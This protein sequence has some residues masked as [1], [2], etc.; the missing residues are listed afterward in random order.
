MRLGTTSLGSV[1]I[2]SR[3]SAR[4]DSRTS[5]ATQC[6]VTPSA[7]SD[8][9]FSNATVDISHVT[10][11]GVTQVLV[12]PRGLTRL[13]GLLLGILVGVRLVLKF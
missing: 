1:S 3:H 13:K 9:T 2:Q 6:G 4:R 7:S 10:S 12:A 11:C 8:A 5:R